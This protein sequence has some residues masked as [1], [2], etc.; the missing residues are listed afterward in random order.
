M[1]ESYK[2]SAAAI[3]DTVMETWSSIEHSPLGSASS[4]LNQTRRLAFLFEHLFRKPASTFRDHALCGAL[5]PLQCIEDLGLARHGRVTLFFFFLDDFF[6]R[7]GDEF[8]VGK[9]GVDPLDVGLGL[10]PFLVEQ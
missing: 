9:L 2:R 4:S 8:L 3:S 10:R 5:E 1:I 7:V 6:R